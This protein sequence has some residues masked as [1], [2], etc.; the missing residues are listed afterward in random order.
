VGKR[1]NSADGPCC[2]ACH[3]AHTLGVAEN[4]RFGRSAEAVRVGRPGD[5]AIVAVGGGEPR[6]VT[7]FDPGG[8]W[9]IQPSWTPDGGSVTFVAEEV[10]RSH[11]NVA[12]VRADGSDLRRLSDGVFRTHPRLRQ[13]G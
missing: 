9:A 12:V 2:V 5:V 4:D 3:V 10:V 7:S 8:G 6:V 13:T 11:P 1:Y